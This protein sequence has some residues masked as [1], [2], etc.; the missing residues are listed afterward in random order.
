MLVLFKF[1]GMDDTATFQAAG[2]RLLTNGVVLWPL[3]EQTSSSSSLGARELSQLTCLILYQMPVVFSF[4][5]F[6]YFSRIDR[7]MLCSVVLGR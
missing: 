1:F 6:F 3:L 2:L 5:D 7:K 4:A